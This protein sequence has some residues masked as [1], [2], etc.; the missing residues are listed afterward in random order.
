MPQYAQLIKA[1]VPAGRHQ[2][3][4][5]TDLLQTTTTA[6][7][8]AALAVGADGHHR[9]GSTARCVPVRPAMLLSTSVWDSSHW[10]HAGL[11]PARGPVL[12]D[13]STRPAA[14][15]IA[16]Q[17][18]QTEQDAD[19]A[20][21]L[22]SGLTELSGARQERLRRSGHRH[23]SSTSPGPTWRRGGV[24]GS[25][26]TRAAPGRARRATSLPARSRARPS[27]CLAP[28]GDHADDDS[29]CADHCPR[30]T[31]GVCGRGRRRICLRRRR[32]VP[33]QP[34][35]ARSVGVERQRH[36][37]AVAS[38][39]V[40]VRLQPGASSPCHGARSGRDPGRARRLLHPHVEPRRRGSA[41]ATSCSHLPMLLGSQWAN[42]VGGLLTGPLFGLLG[43]RWRTRRSWLSAALIAGALCLEP[44]ARWGAGRLSPPALAWQIEIAAGA[45]LALFR[46]RRRDPRP[47]GERRVVRRRRIST[48]DRST[49]CALLRST[50]R[51]SEGTARSRRCRAAPAQA[52]CG[53]GGEQVDGAAR[54]VRSKGKLERQD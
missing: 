23:L 48:A 42:I 35:D 4:H 47:F 46:R 52:P 50:S 40:P 36:V 27:S 20:H 1:H 10:H 15:K 26:M 30:T 53:I 44:A 21:L 22:A 32:P 39:T 9:L 33:G 54:D 28:W 29:K 13:P 24:A 38:A 11:R 31:T 45:A 17:M 8:P 41:A 18:A 2:R 43:Q 12:R 19:A 7:N 49:R 3:H 37:G 5:R 6:G 25:R 51:R 34:C 16:T 14:L